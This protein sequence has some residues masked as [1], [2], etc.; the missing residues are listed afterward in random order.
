[1]GRVVV[2]TRV[3]AGAALGAVLTLAGAGLGCTRPNPAFQGGSGVQGMVATGGTTGARTTSTATGGGGGT[4]RTTGSILDVGSMP[5]SS[6]DGDSESSETGGGPDPLAECC[7]SG[8][9][10]CVPLVD[11]NCLC[12]EVPGCCNNWDPLCLV[13]AVELCGLSCASNC[14]FGHPEPGCSDPEVSDAVCN[15]VDGDP[16]CCELSWLDSCATAAMTMYDACLAP[17]SCCSEHPTPGCDDADVMAAVCLFDP[18]CCISEWDENC[19]FAAAG[20]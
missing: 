4:G 5:G 17:Q 10:E 2:S 13:P 12:A 11:S 19:V 20:C 3:V 1:M 9:E 8:N 14:C 18:Y 6:D 7:A 15:G 16:T